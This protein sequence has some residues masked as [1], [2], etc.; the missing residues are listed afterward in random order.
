MGDMLRKAYGG[1][2]PYDYGWPDDWEDNAIDFVD[3]FPTAAEMRARK[4]SLTTSDKIVL[5][6]IKERL[7]GVTGGTSITHEGC[8]SIAVTKFLCE[9]GYKIDRDRQ[10]N[11]EYTIISWRE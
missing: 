10:Y 9:K 1:F 11:T 8:L 7:N 4:D 3:D 5:D 6:E 2:A